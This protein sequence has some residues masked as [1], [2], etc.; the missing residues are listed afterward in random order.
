[1]TDELLSSADQDAWVSLVE[2]TR[3]KLAEM[4]PL[5]PAMKPDEVKAFADTVNA[6]MWTHV[7]ASTFDKAVS[8]ELSRV[9]AFD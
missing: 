3:A 2:Q 7:K 5:L 8:L 9:T 6:L 4:V 1:M